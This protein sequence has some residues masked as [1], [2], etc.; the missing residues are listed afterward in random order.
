MK[1]NDFDTALFEAARPLPVH[2]PQRGWRT[3]IAGLKTRLEK[4]WVGLY[5]PPPRRLRPLI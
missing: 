2:R 3:A 4:A 1:L 5:A